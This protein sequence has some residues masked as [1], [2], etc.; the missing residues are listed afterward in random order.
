MSK[1][2]DQQYGSIPDDDFA[3]FQDQMDGQYDPPP[4]QPEVPVDKPQQA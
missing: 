2:Q 3:D 4:K 1:Q